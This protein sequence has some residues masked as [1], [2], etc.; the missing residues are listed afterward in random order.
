ML[1]QLDLNLANMQK[2]QP[3]LMHAQLLCLNETIHFIQSKLKPLEGATEKVNK[4]KNLG[5]KN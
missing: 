4:T 2:C 5:D 3:I 1:T